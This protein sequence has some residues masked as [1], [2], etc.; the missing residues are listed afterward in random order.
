MEMQFLI[1]IIKRNSVC[2]VKE[3]KTQTK[4]FLWE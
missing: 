3:R 2:T 4:V 1:K